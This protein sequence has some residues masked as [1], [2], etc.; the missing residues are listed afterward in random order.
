MAVLVVE[1]GLLSFIRDALEGYTNDVGT[2]GEPDVF[3]VDI[4]VKGS[5]PAKKIEVLVDTDAGISI[6][7]CVSITCWLRN[8]L[9]V[10]E[11]VMRLVG[12][13]YVL[14]VSSPGIG[15]PIKH[16][17]Q[18]IRQTGRLLRVQYTDAEN[19]SREVSGRLIRAEVLEVAGPF[20]VLE[21]VK[22]GK[23]RKQEHFEPV[24]LDLSRISRA[25]VEVEF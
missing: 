2:S 6:A 17:R 22:A 24:R 9:E 7:Q 20:I 12:D 3:L 23:G 19:A 8:A 4:F 18:Y 16:A 11:E 25:V 15:A 13:D 14:T 1:D 21:P 10:N 5:G